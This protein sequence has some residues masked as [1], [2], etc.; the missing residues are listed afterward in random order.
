MITRIT[1]GAS[2][3]SVFGAIEGAVTKGKNGRRGSYQNIATASGRNFDHLPWIVD[4]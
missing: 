1:E 2:R 3:E 4:E